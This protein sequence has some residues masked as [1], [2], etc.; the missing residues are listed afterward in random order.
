MLTVKR[1]GGPNMFTCTTVIAMLAPC[2]VILATL[3][4]LVVSFA[5]A[6]TTERLG[7]PARV[8]LGNLQ[9]HATGMLQ[10]EF[11]AK[12]WGTVQAQLTLP[13]GVYALQ[14]Q[15]NQRPRSQVRGNAGAFRLS[16]ASGNGCSLLIWSLADRFQAVGYRVYRRVQNGQEQLLTPQPIEDEIYA[17][18]GL[19]NGQE[20]GYR[21]VALDR[22]GRPVASSGWV[23]VTP[24][25]SAPL[26]KWSLAPTQLSGNAVMRVRLS[27]GEP[28][29]AVMVFVD[30]RLAG[31]G[32]LAPDAPGEV[33]VTF[34]TTAFP[35]GP[36]RIKVAGYCAESVA[37]TPVW[38]AV[39]SNPISAF[40]V[41]VAFEAGQSVPIRAVL[42]KG[43]VRWRVDILRLLDDV[44]VR[45]H[46]GAGN[47]V[48]WTWDGKNSRG[49]PVDNDTYDVRIT[50]IDNQG[51]VH[52]ESQSTT[53][54]PRSRGGRR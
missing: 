7:A 42:P 44:V 15:G 52:V 31:S 18:S 5:S 36:R 1:K 48:D 30:D 6:Q 21:V 34:A 50:A 13:V 49:R 41:S 14:A 24:T 27:T 35:N 3:W 17:D 46:Q 38:T 32:G 33:A 25:S 51:R 45:S 9:G 20:Y 47:I 37:V 4:L 16:V 43:T 8:Q 40:T 10:Q 39:F 54:L 53:K 22:A 19:V 29:G 26:L 28:V 12:R 2:N 23:R 11:R